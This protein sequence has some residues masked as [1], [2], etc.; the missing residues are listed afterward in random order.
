MPG[1]EL[2]RGE[3]QFQR[4]PNMVPDG[5]F[6]N[7]LPCFCVTELHHHERGIDD[8]VQPYGSPWED[9]VKCEEE[10]V[11][12][13]RQGIAG[14]IV[15]RDRDSSKADLFDSIAWEKVELAIERPVELERER[16]VE[17]AEP[18]GQ[19]RVG[20]GSGFIADMR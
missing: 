9:V 4:D 3:G 16:R 1:P 8:P 12:C 18:R 10:E 6:D 7:P 17:R 15:P 13:R 11:V 2:G 20:R 5:P 14:E 19:G